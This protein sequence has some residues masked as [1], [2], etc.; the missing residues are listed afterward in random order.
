[1]HPT[2]GEAVPGHGA[3]IPARTFL[4]RA[5]YKA[6]V[7]H[8]HSRAGAPARPPLTGNPSAR[9]GRGTDADVVAAS[10]RDPA[11]F[12]EL[13]ERHWE[14]LYRFCHSR[15][16]SAGE[17]IAAEAFRRAF[18]RR[19]RYDSRHSDARPWLFGI[20]TNLLRDHFRSAR[21]EANKL[22]RSVALGARSESNAELDGP[23]RELLGHDLVEALESIP[24]ADRDA[25]LLMVWA[26]LDYEQIAQALDIRLGTVRS[27][28]HRARQRVR[29]YLET[30]EHDAV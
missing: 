3:R 2:A 26:D 17:D 22:S 1:M 16:G 11:A 24:A 28:I 7:E 30:H 10:L 23:E 4:F 29:E 12:A 5:T 14:D 20:A 19:R 21:R 13:F 15:A 8:T 18:D 27:R 9:A 25:L 6:T